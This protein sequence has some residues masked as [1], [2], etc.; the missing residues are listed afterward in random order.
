M[1][2]KDSVQ[3]KKQLSEKLPE[4]K[5]SVTRNDFAGGHSVNV[6]VL[7]GPFQFFANDMLE[8]VK[9]D[10]LKFGEINIKRMI[11]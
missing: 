8:T 10:I 5:F 2:D 4:Y 11:E 1:A 9:M 3:I 7:S 6:R